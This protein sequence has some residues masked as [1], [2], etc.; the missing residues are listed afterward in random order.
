MNKIIISDEDLHRVENLQSISVEEAKTYYWLPGEIKIKGNINQAGH[1]AFKSRCKTDPTKGE[2]C[3]FI[4]DPNAE[5]EEYT[6]HDVDYDIK[7]KPKKYK[8]G[9]ISKSI[10]KW[11]RNL[12]IP[13]KNI[14]NKP[15]ITVCPVKNKKDSTDKPEIKQ[16]DHEYNE[17]IITVQKDSADKPERKQQDHE[18]GEDL[19][20]HEKIFCLGPKSNTWVTKSLIV[21]MLRKQV[22]DKVGKSMLYM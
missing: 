10:M 18:H 15:I 21:W 14:H 12:I 4:E 22:V 16:Q 7:V 19:D 17:P 20:G 3:T 8:H 2:H 6:I 1:C 11:A 9:R 13:Q 5:P